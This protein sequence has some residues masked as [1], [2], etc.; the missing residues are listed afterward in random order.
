MILTLADVP[1]Q[2]PPASVD[3]AAMFRLYQVG[4]HV[5]M[6]AEQDNAFLFET[7]DGS[8][9]LYLVQSTEGVVAVTQVGIIPDVGVSISSQPVVNSRAWDIALYLQANLTEP[10]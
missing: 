5:L 7:P 10:V 6:A 2:V 3:E 8:A 9:G 4:E 1:E